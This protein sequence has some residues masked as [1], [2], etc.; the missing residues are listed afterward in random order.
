MRT[1][2]IALDDDKLIEVIAGNGCEGMLAAHELKR[3]LLTRKK[4]EPLRQAFEKRMG[5]PPERLRWSIDGS[6]GTR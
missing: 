5:Y 1:N 6:E 2:Y 4:T 3:R